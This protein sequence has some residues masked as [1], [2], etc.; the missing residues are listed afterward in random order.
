M[1]KVRLDSRPLYILVKEKIDEL[2]CNG[3]FSLGSRLPSENALADDLGVSRATLREAL[4]ALEE[5][6]KIIRQQGIGTFIAPHLSK[7][8]KG[9]EDLVSVT[10][11][12]ES[13]GFRPGTEGYT[14]WQEEM[15]EISCV[16]EQQPNDLMWVIERIRTA[17]QEPVV[18]CKDYLSQKL[19]PTKLDLT[20]NPYGES[21]FEVLEKQYHL[22]I[23]H[24]IAR[25][26]PL[27]APDW[28]AANLK[29]VPEIPLLLLEQ[30][31]YD[32]KEQ[33]IIFSRNYF[34]H[35]KIEFQVLRK[36]H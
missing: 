20:K 11:T 28:L 23:T 3:T 10:E 35:D 29:I 12:I 16:F 21:I 36:R 34:R 8:Q 6:G 27:T 17:N 22:R 9:I 5:E 1:T 19:V 15:G 7:M 32:Q 14:I 2:I 24:A 33:L 31:H 4:R 13:Q 18:Y 26:I 25:I 30:R